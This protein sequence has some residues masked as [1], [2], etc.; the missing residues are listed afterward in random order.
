MSKERRKLAFRDG[1]LEWNR[2]SNCRNMPWKG[3][4]NP[5]LI[6]LSEIILQQTRVEQGLEYYNKFARTFPT[7]FDLAKAEDQKVLKLWEGLGYY[8]RC[9][10][11]LITARYIAFELGGIFPDSY[12]GL[13]KLKGIGPY[14]AAAIASFAYSLP[15]AVL[16]GNVYRI[17]SRY[18][19]ID[20]PVNDKT[21]KKF[22]VLSNKLL[23]RQ[24]PAVYNQAIMDFG[25][26]VC[27]P[28][29]P[30]CI[31]CP[32]QQGCTAYKRNEVLKFPVKV[33]KM[34][35]RKRYFNYMVIE[36][37]SGILIRRREQKDIWEGLHEP[38]LIESEERNLSSS[39]LAE[40]F[41]LYG[42][43]QKVINEKTVKQQLSH[44][45]IFSRFFHF[46]LDESLQVP[47]Y[48]VVAPESMRELAFP[49]SI[50]NYLSS[51]NLQL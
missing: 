47:G 4:K 12:E 38:V 31:N 5:Y 24:D 28:K 41:P 39:E 44:Q 40:H 21:N 42:K 29:S 36:S 49:L 43:A 9:R 1:L 32:L 37:G 2:V 3:E 23:C 30:A 11:L 34:K 35:K 16:D 46:R 19:A 15:H 8:S 7:I 14:T 10:N 50:R 51:V 48:A 33:N 17:L 45:E 26:T 6:W 22:S 13:L 27:T 18:F 25:A 20:T